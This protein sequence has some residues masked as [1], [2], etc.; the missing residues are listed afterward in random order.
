VSLCGY[1]DVSKER[2]ALILK[3]QRSQRRKGNI[4]SW[5]REPFENNCT[6]VFR[7]SGNTNPA[8]LCH[9]LEELGPL[10]HCCTNLKTRAL[11]KLPVPQYVQKYRTFWLWSCALAHRVILQIVTYVSKDSTASEVPLPWTL[12]QPILPKCWQLPTNQ[13]GLMLLISSFM[14]SQHKV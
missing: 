13:H 8:L 6:T 9:I 2:G 3:G 5:T 10:Q 14:I 4:F 1:P 7:T 11:I 12:R